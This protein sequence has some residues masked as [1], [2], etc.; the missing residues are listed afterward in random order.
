MEEVLLTRGRRHSLRA[1]VCA[2]VLAAAVLWAAACS[3]PHAA[4]TPRS[5]DAPA[6]QQRVAGAAGHPLLLVFWATWCKPCIEELPA[7]VALRT[8]S[9][10]G[11]QVTAVS[12]D[13]FLSGDSALAV[14]RDFLTA[15][16]APLDHLV[17]RGSQD[18]LFSAFD[19]PGNIPY[20]VLYD[21]H[22]QVLQRF[23]GA[24]D[25]AAV[26]AALRPS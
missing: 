15:N 22:G 6:L 17:Y 10:S 20:A 3:H 9:P 8:E 24:V 23:A 11:L 5:A 13:V 25:P 12:L 1:G 14:V 16:P 26:R 18:A 19:L 4:G 21:G 7:L 2:G